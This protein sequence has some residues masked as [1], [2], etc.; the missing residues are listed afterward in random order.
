MPW[1]RIPFWTILKSFMLRNYIFNRPLT[2]H[3]TIYSPQLSSLLSIWHRLAGVILV[4]ILFMTFLFLEL[5][6]NLELNPFK[7]VLIN[8]PY[9]V[10]AFFYLIFSITFVY[11][12][13]NGFRHIFWDLLL[14]LKHTS[15]LISSIA[16]LIFSGII[17]L[18]TI[19][20][21]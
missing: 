9:W 19:T 16:V 11:H 10:I 14:L 18:K 17:I 15:V 2:P 12:G 3:L 7:I 5:E 21:L 4:L 1:V 13:L 8:S 20:T 6:F